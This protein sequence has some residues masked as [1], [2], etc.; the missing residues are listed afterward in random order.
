MRLCCTSYMQ[1]IKHFLF[2]FF[3]FFFWYAGTLF[4]WLFWP[5]FNAALVVGNAQTR[6]V[7]NTYYSMTGSVI[8]AFIFSMFFTANRKLSMVCLLSTSLLPS[9]S[10]FFTCTHKAA[11]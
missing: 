6:A 8:A 9:H 7:V 3:F 5:S 4:L 2:F 1:A 11:C 10:Y